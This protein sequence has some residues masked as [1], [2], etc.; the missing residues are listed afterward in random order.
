MVCILFW[1]KRGNCFEVGFEESTKGFS[2]R[3][4][5]KSLHAEG[6][7]TE[8]VL[9]P[10]VESLVREI[11]RL[12]VWEAERRIL[13]EKCRGSQGEGRGEGEKKKEKKNTSIN[14][15]TKKKIKKKNKNNTE[16][17]KLM[18]VEH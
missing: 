14:N 5:G 15:Y 9:E 12:R 8:R 7:Q 11:G 16:K 3:G 1:K 6:S 13:T 10:I 2:R 18:K 17:K 4:R